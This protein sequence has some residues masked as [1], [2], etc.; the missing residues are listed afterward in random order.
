MRT[1]YGTEINMKDRFG[2]TI[3]YMRISITD[4]CNLRCT[5]C[6]P[7]GITCV[8]MQELL[9]YEEI[10]VVCAQAVF[11]GISRF[12]ITGGEPLVRRDCVSLVSM[13]RNIKGVEQV[14]LTTNG[15][16]LGEHLEEL[17]AGGISAVNISLDTMDHEQYRAI[18][19]SD[20]LDRVLSAIRM[21][22]GRL[23]VKIN[24]VVQSGVNEDAPLYLAMLAREMPVDV[25]F[26]EM[27]PIGAGRMQ[28]TVPNG[29]IQNRLEEKYGKSLPDETIHGN[30]PAVYR[31]FEGFTGSIGFISAMH[32]KFCSSCNRLRLTSTG[33][34]KPCLCYGDVIPLRD[35]LRDGEPERDKRIREKL[36]EAVAA[37]PQMHCF[38]KSEDI[39]EQKR[40][41][42]I[43][44]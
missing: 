28:K 1:T 12:K 20:E 39:T 3:N 2:R 38:E 41:A 22:A 29:M 8:P 35:I 7:D 30:G 24:C 34:L 5:Y 4:R 14:T 23:P 9:S 15:V 33:D 25:R 43:G 11:L 21:A 31:R 27:M 44:G 37:K 13:L 36:K 18:T 19:G 32:G 6:L 16:L 40:M 26:I 17:M 42:Q 10:A